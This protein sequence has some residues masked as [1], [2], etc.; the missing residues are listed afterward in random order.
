[1]ARARLRAPTLAAHRATPRRRY[2]QRTPTS[3]SNQALAGL[4]DDVARR[5]ASGE[6]L[7]HAFNTSRAVADLSPLFDRT[8]IALHRGATFAE[9][10]AQQ[11][12]ES[13]GVALVVHIL[14]VC[15]RAGGNVSEPLDRAAATLR[16]RHAAS[17]ERIAQSAQ[18]RLSVRVLT[19]VPVAFASW[20]VLTSGDVQHFMLSPA[21]VI[22]VALGLAL[23]A[24]GWRVMQRIIG[25][26]R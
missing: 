14:G 20:T 4:L 15:A 10:L 7:T 11:P 19:L 16:E 5:C 9:A 17:Q 22:C 3:P 8:L 13:A 21:G 1:M 12:A 23:N 26:S 25:G 24:A 2:G 18:A 6:T